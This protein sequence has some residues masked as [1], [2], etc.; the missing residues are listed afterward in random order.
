MKFIH[1]N[2]ETLRELYHNQLRL[3]LSIELQIADALPDMIQ[4]ATDIELKQAFHSHLQETAAQ[5]VRVEG[6]LKEETKDVKAET[7]KVLKALVSEAEDMIKDSN[8]PTVRDAALISA[9]QRVEH[10]EMA[11]YGAVRQWALVLG[12]NRQ[13]ELLDE[14]LKEESRADYLLTEIASRIN[15][16]A[17]K[18]A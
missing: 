2:L 18:A 11:V 10:Y 13:A 4:R 17:D 7:C 5:V 3:L 12:K 1:A 8:D 15:I 6:I 14:T 16:E 9:A